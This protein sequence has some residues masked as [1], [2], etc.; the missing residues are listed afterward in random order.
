MNLPSHHVK[1]KKHPL[2]LNKLHK[3]F[4]FFAPYQLKYTC[5][6]CL[7]LQFEAR[8]IVE[9][10]I[11]EANRKVFQ[12]IVED[13][14]SDLIHEAEDKANLKLEIEQSRKFNL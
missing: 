1:S 12:T 13:F 14:L 6:L 8:E 10:V 4:L 5:V 7:D 3:K 2:S 11:D 9:G